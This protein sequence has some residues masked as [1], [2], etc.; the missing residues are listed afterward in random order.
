MN[1]R[2]SNLLSSEA[3][4]KLAIGLLFGGITAWAGWITNLAHADALRV[5]S[6]EAR[7]VNVEKTLNDMH[8]KI[9]LL[10]DRTTAHIDGRS[11]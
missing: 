6:Y 2:P 4:L 9:D 5:A 8:A 10:L 11:Q 1:Q 7:I 3:L